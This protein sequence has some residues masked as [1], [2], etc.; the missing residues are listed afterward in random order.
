M[1]GKRELN[2]ITIMMGTLAMLFGCTAQQQNVL[3]GSYEPLRD[4]S[5]G[6]ATAVIEGSNVGRDCWV[7]VPANAKTLVVDAGPVSISIKC[8]T[9]LGLM[10]EG[11]VYSKFHFV[12]EAG[13]TYRFLA[14]DDDCM[15]LMD[16]T[17]EERLV[18]CRPYYPSPYIDL[19]TG[20]ATAVIWDSPV[21][22]RCICCRVVL[23]GD[24]AAGN[25]RLDRYEAW[26]V[27]AGPITATSECRVGFFIT[28]SLFS[29]F[30]FEAEPGH[31]YRVRMQKGECTRLVDVTSDEQLI[32]C[33]PATERK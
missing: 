23:V 11:L 30:K 5:T 1:F 9:L 10:R 12:A 27:D 6:E 32:A 29:N 26:E 17:S 15:A 24:K 4:L 2:K 14:R 33:E 28:K 31:T 7:S 25:G 8:S 19:S 3:A 16:V 21:C 18:T 20:D 13:H 22:S